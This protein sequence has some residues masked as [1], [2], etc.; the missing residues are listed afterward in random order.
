M[1]QRLPSLLNKNSS[2]K[3][4]ESVEKQCWPKFNDPDGMN[5]VICVSLIIFLNLIINF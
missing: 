3:L 5:I 4:D 1:L 2:W